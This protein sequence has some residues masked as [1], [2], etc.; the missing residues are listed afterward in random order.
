MS[1][2]MKLIMERWGKFKLQEKIELETVGQ[3]KIFVKQH[4]AA[5][6]GKEAGK[7]AVDTILG[8]LPG[9]GNVYTV[10]KGTKTAVDSLNKIYGANDKIKSNTGLDALNVDD[11]VSKID[12]GDDEPLPNA[13]TELQSFLA[14]SFEDNTVKK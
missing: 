6:A 5:E 7:F 4:R 9:I 3:F 10:L 13:T 1:K 11:N 8:A 12:M 2:E 14:A